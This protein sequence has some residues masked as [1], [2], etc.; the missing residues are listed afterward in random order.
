MHQ[1]DPAANRPQLQDPAHAD[2]RQHDLVLISGLAADDLTAADQSMATALT[3]SCADCRALR[4]DLL[5]IAQ[6]TRDLPAQRAPRDFRITADQAARLTRTGWFARLVGSLV[7]SGSLVRPLA[8]TFTT[9]G[10]VGIFVAG[11]L[12]TMLGGAASMP[13]PEAVTGLGGTGATTASSAPGAMHGPQL[14]SAG[15]GDDGY[16]VK[17]AAQASAEPADVRAGSNGETSGPDAQSLA[18][19]GDERANGLLLW[20]SVTL[21]GVGLG[22]F[23]LR[24]AGRRLR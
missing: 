2:H 13:A 24:L 8:A 23:A 7:G 6:A 19:S 17:D 9:L 4:D 1:N 3:E 21:L 18:R 16:G 10:L 14:A 15:P 12:P 5:T 20:G 22:L 11:A